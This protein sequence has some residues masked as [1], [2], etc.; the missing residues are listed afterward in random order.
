MVISQ[1]EIDELLN[2]ALGAPDE[3]NDSTN[4]GK[5]RD[6]KVYRAPRIEAKRINFP[7]KSP[8]VKSRNVIYNPNNGTDKFAVT[9]KVI[10]RSLDNYMEYIVKKEHV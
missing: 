3:G 10:V 6:D 9:D 8:I 5:V 2:N 4:T 7:Y 1:N